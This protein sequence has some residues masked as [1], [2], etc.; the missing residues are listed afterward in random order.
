MRSVK[1]IDIREKRV[2]IRCDFNVPMKNGRIEDDSRI[3]ATLPTLQF[4][5]DGGAKVIACSHLGKP[6]GERVTDLSLKP[7]ADRL[8]EL[9][10]R[11][12]TMAS[13]CIGSEVSEQAA[14][15]GAGQIMLLENLR[16]HHGETKNDP[17]F[18]RQ[19][20]ELADVYV[21]DAFGVV[22]RAHA[23][24]AG[25]T[26]HFDTVSAG[27]LLTKEVE[28]LT[29]AT[30]K[31]EHPYVL[32]SGGA[33][34]SSKIA[35]LSNLMDKVDRI[36]I[37]GAMA[38]TFRKAQ[39]YGVGSSKIEEDM[40]DQAAAILDKAKQNRVSFYLPVDFLTGKDPETD[41]PGGV[42][43]YQDIPAEEML[44]DTGPAS[45][46]LF[47]EVL[48]EAR[49]VVWNGPMGAFENPTFSQ[50]SV[51]LAQTVAKLEATTIV[52]GGD[53]DSLI[54]K[55]GLQEQMSFIST[56]GGSFLEYLEGKELPG[57]KALEK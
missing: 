4:L 42:Y 43:P 16:F 20:A 51:G 50:G 54:H 24:V 36:I 13:D 46:T 49:T 55:C 38:N 1:D 27:L 32:I 41:T 53:T 45:H 40:L 47:S 19:L 14:G 29:M 25:V 30:A 11:P 33:K 21:N 57:L 2:L 17:E 6:K 37:G 28:Y 48:K 8:K 52:G 34:V 7:V 9:L 56:G 23:S 10:D 31:P 44:L 15:L 39:G 12:V 3:K 26:E 35:L 22:H 18:S 5:L